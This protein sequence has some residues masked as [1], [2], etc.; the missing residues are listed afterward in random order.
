MKMKSRAVLRTCLFAQP[1]ALD[2]YSNH[3]KL[4]RSRCANKNSSQTLGR[5]VEIEWNG[6]VYLFKALQDLLRKQTLSSSR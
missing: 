4:G 1:R 2:A 5:L 6:Y 3:R